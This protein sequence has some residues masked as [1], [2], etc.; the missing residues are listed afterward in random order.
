MLL[1][2]ESNTEINSQKINNCVDAGEAAGGSLVLIRP[3]NTSWL[4]QSKIFKT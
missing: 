4:V 1:E 2:H 3:I